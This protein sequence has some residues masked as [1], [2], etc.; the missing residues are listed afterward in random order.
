M[1]TNFFA[2]LGMTVVLGF[3]T[4]DLPLFKWMFFYRVSITQGRFNRSISFGTL[5]YCVKLTN[6]T[7]CS[8]LMFVNELGQL[9]PFNPP[10]FMTGLLTFY[11]IS[12]V[13]LAKIYPSKF[14]KGPG[15]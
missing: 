10:L 2:V 13:L 5:G 12:M 11:Q 15:S 1:K 3:V 7:T 8:K 9:S 14:L 6:G 4:L